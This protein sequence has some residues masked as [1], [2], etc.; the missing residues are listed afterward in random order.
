[1]YLYLISISFFNGADEGMI[2]TILLLLTERK[3]K[4]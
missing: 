2:R 3:R 4:Q 1:M